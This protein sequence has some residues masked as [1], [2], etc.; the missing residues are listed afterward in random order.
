M[1]KMQ[2]SRFRILLAFAML[3]ALV[4]IAA[5]P[6]YGAHNCGE[7]GSDDY[8]QCVSLSDH[9]ADTGSSSTVWYATGGSMNL[10]CD[11]DDDTPAP[12]CS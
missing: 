7:E 5:L 4:G 10:K 12:P 1:T 8:N 9:G 3:V 6:A 11:D 2:V